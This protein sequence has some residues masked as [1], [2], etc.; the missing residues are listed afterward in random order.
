MA[1]IHVSKDPVTNVNETIKA[2]QNLNTS[3]DKLKQTSAS[4]PTCFEF[5]LNTTSS[6]VW[7]EDELDH[8]LK[9]YP[10]D[11]EGWVEVV[12]ANASNDFH[13]L[14][15]NIDFALVQEMDVKIG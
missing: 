14:G 10:Q 4:S 2:P 11:V 6:H 3:K 13:V 8:V 7:S 9:N 15:V 12:I 1:A 5:D